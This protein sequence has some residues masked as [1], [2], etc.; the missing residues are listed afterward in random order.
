MQT[1]EEAEDSLCI[2]LLE[3]YAIVLET[4]DPVAMIRFSG[5]TYFEGAIGVAVFDGVREQVLK[6]MPKL[7]G[8]ARD[9]G[10]WV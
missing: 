6:D 3:A 8:I 4:Y 2:L 5:D 7:S 10:Q 9:G 1:L